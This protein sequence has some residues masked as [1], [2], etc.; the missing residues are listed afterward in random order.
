MHDFR[1]RFAVLQLSAGVQLIRVSKWLGHASYVIT[2]TVS[3]DYIPEEAAANP[4]PDPG[5]PASVDTGNV[6]NLHR[7]TAG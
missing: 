3:A 1:H 6:V 2:L 5:A 4:L 7:S